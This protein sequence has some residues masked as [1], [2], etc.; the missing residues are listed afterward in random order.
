MKYKKVLLNLPE[1]VASD[2][3]KFANAVEDGNKSQFAAKA[4]A[5]QVEYYR[6]LLHT[7]KMRDAYAASAEEGLHVTQEWKLL[8]D[9]LWSRL[10][11][12][13]KKK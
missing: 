12:I 1:T 3:E 6:K 13:E 5:G 7:A 4:I 8:D 9:E 2:L 11:E 10:D